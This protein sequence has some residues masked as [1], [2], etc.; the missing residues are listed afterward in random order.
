[1]L[2]FTCASRALAESLPSML[3][4]DFKYLA[5]NAE[6]DGEDLLAAPSHIDVLSRPRVAFTLVAA[7]A[8]LGGAFALDETIR[9]THLDHMSSDDALLLEQVGLYSLST[10][11]GLLYLYGLIDS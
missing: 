3:A 11:E 1:M 9:A 10:G 6:A 2:T 5:N 8:A 4:S 7:G